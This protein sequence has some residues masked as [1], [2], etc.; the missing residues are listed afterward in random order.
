MH[1]P[2]GQKKENNRPIWLVLVRGSGC[3][4]LHRIVDCFS[5]ICLAVAA[6][7]SLNIRF[8]D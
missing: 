2:R 8:N 3:Y 6:T 4:V 7:G 1:A 5:F